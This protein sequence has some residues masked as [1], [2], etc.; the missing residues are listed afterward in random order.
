MVFVRWHGI[1]MVAVVQWLE[2]QSVE[3]V[4]WVRIP[5]VTL[6]ENDM[7]E[8]IKDGVTNIFQEHVRS[9]EAARTINEAIKIMYR[10]NPN[11]F[12]YTT[13]YTFIDV[14]TLDEIMRQAR[15]NAGI[16]KTEWGTPGEQA[17]K[18]LD[19]FAIVD[20]EDAMEIITADHAYAG[21]SRPDFSRY[22]TDYLMQWAFNIRIS[23]N[24]KDK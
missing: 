20:K 2:H 12:S 17:K 11:T 13:E 16:I 3:L 8:T 4:I 15:K 18:F 9:D 14:S 1:I 10:Y 22:S 6:K 5:S 19:K 24:R 7:D 23:H 21:Y